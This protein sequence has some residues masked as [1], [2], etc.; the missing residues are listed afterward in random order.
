M[1]RRRDATMSEGFIV[2]EPV[3]HGA[4]VL[5]HATSAKHVELHA[6]RSGIALF[7][8]VVAVRGSRD[9]KPGALSHD[10]S[11]KA[12]GLVSVRLICVHRYIAA[13]GDP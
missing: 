2:W 10:A 7:V 8:A 1:A 6:S 12:P 13:H 9:A 4:G 11:V 5:S 3:A